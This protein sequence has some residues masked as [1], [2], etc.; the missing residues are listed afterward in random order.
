MPDKFSKVI[1][2]AGHASECQ[3]FHAPMLDSFQFS[4]WRASTISGSHFDTQSAEIRKEA[5][6]LLTKRYAREE[7]FAGR[8][9]PPKEALKVGIVY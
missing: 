8:V 6:E 4:I 7:V 9:R 1:L 2:V 5:R 3:I